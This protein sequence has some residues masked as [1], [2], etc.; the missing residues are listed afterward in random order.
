MLKIDKSKVDFLVTATM[1]QEVKEILGRDLPKIKKIVNEVL[2][3]G[4]ERVYFVA[5][6]SPLSAAETAKQLFDLYSSIPCAAYSGWD[7][8]DNTP[9][10]SPKFKR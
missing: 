8:C 10:K 5:C 9:K 7:F 6:G 2:E 1:V 4:I 3:R